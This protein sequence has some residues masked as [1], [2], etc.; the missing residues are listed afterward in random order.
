VIRD[1]RP[2]LGREGAV[3]DV[4]GSAEAKL[5]WG[6]KRLRELH[7][8]VRELNE[9]NPNP[10]RLELADGGVSVYRRNSAPSLP[11]DVSLMVGEILYAFRSALDCAV[12][13]IS[14]RSPG[15]SPASCEFPI[16]L[17]ASRG[18]ASRG[19]GSA[20][21]PDGLKKIRFL[22][23]D[24]KEIVQR[25]QPYDNH[26]NPVRAPMWRLNQLRN[27]DQHRNLLMAADTVVIQAVGFEGPVEEDPANAMEFHG[28]GFNAGDPLLTIADRPRSK[29]TPQAEMKVVFM[30]EGDL[31]G[32]DL[33]SVLGEI[34]VKV[35]GAVRVLGQCSASVTSKRSGYS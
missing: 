33:L 13:S 22:A 16:F 24:A 8:L 5:A 20:F 2:K 4:P 23:D 12:Y 9:A 6:I 15:F 25:Y 18:V 1:G 10:T 32:A 35:Q 28:P 31:R 17:H 21:D 14:E 19:A 7:K 29:F 30:E 34:Q 3:T 11:P 27:I 26:P